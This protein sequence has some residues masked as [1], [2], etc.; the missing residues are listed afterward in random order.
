MKRLLAVLL[1]VA[2]LISMT[3]CGG[4]TETTPTTQPSQP[5]ETT[6][7]AP[8]PVEVYNAAASTLASSANVRMDIT[9]EKEM[10][11][12]VETFTEK[13]S[14]TVTMK[15]IGTEQFL[16]S[17]SGAIYWADGYWTE[18]TEI[19]S[20]GKLY[21]A[22]DNYAYSADM[23]QEDFLSRC[24]PVV[25][26]DPA[27]YSTAEFVNDTTIRFADARAR[28]S[29][30]GDGYTELLDASAEVKLDA[31]GGINNVSCTFSYRQGGV[32]VQ[33]TV[34]AQMFTSAYNV[35]VPEDISLFIPTDSPDA[36]LAYER[37]IGMLL[38]AESI[39]SAT[40]EAFVISA[41][42][43]SMSNQ[44]TLNAFGSGADLMGQFDTNIV[45][46]DLSTGSPFSTYT[47]QEIYR[48][49][50]YSI[51]SDGG[52]AQE[53]PTVTED[54][55]RTYIQN[56]ASGIIPIF[57][58]LAGMTMKDQTGTA[59]LEFT[60]TDAY[61][62]SF[63]TFVC[64]R[65]YEDPNLLDSVATAYRTETAEGYMG[66][67]T[68]TGLPTMVAVTYL[69]YHTIDGAE[70]PVAY[71]G[72]STYQF[73]AAT[74]YETITGTEL[75]LE[76]PEEKATPLL[77]HV[78]GG[79]GE[80]M[81]LFGTIHVGD[82][83]TSFLPAE[84]TDAL[85]SS[86]A[87]AVEFDTDSFMEQAMADPELA[88]LIAS[89]YY[90]TDGTSILDHMED[91]SLFD[92]ASDRLKGLGGYN[93]LAAA[94]RPFVL[95]LT[96]DNAYLALGHDLTAD[97][98][99]D[100]Q[101]MKLAR[102]QNIEI[103]DV[104]SGESQMQMFAGFSDP[105]QELLLRTTLD[106]NALESQAATSKLYELWCS[107]DEAALAQMIAE[108]VPELTEAEKLLYEEFVKAMYTDRNAAMLDAAKG[109]LTGGDTVFYAVGLAHLLAED[110]LVNTLRDAGY[111]VEPVSYD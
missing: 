18:V 29:W 1:C 2:L 57:T 50:V 111:T 52:A 28:E 24:W 48:D 56:T 88:A 55:I 82:A 86:D 14:T 59:L 74:P 40:T 69:G 32:Q 94:C 11:I 42:M 19:Y 84:L 90:Y 92:E 47:Q 7:P 73:A 83:R 35:E 104:E 103:L 26:L 43:V 9:S 85:S 31:A 6:V 77:Y 99:A 27:N 98:G 58:D 30:L 15:D 71:E 68:V 64:G 72:T 54:A 46:T 38:Q 109:Y 25:L 87:L 21:G 44:E 67:D 37:A 78:T 108:D 76:Q 65:I 16:A 62:D 3:A 97:Q 49:G 106:T 70:Q 110:G 51:S 91:D 41:G 80:E 95:A 23:S 96:I 61:A 101:L 63:S 5:T 45:V 39:Q 53:D 100:A 79:E 8:D 10:V 4:E 34:H 105:L 22:V 75:A 81:W 33:Q 107:G 20:A 93:A 13:E 12:G 17:S 36:P 102:E 66:I 60:F 89:S